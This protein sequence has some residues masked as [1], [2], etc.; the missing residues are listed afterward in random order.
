MSDETNWP[1]DIDPQS[2]FRLPLL[3][4]E[5]LDEVG[6]RQEGHDRPSRVEN[7][8]GG[9]LAQHSAGKQRRQQESRIVRCRVVLGR[10]S[11]PDGCVG[12]R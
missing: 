1:A 7:H 8:D 6:Q 9:P 2:G 4:R 3:K 10:C 5:E 11:R 12:K